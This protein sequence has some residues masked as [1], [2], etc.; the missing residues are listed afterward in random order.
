[1]AA[2]YQPTELM[3]NEREW[4]DKKQG[5]V[6]YFLTRVLTGQGCFVVYLKD[7]KY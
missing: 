4:I 5:E 1:M 2:E 3:I 7:S 6:D